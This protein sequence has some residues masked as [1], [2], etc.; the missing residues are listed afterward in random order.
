[1]V[2]IIQTLRVSTKEAK[3]VTLLLKWVIY[4]LPIIECCFLRVRWICLFKFCVSERW[5]DYFAKIIIINYKSIWLILNTKWPKRIFNIFKDIFSAGIKIKLIFLWIK[6]II[7]EKSFLFLAWYCFT[8]QISTFQSLF[9]LVLCHLRIV[10]PIPR[11]SIFN[12]TLCWFYIFLWF[13][14]FISY[15][16]KYFIIVI[17][18]IF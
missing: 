9:Y 10:L 6:N 16:S 2:I 15:S 13:I 5:K 18:C 11:N 14:L 3:R 1:L 17:C 4:S 12:L 8:R 7:L